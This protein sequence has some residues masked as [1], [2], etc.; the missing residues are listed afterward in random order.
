MPTVTPEFAGRLLFQTFF[1]G[2]FYAVNADGSELRR[3]TDGIDPIW[4]PDG[5]QIAFTRWRE[6]RGLWVVDANNPAS[7]RRV[8]D[9]NQVR[10]S[11]WSPDAAELLFSRMTGAG[12]QEE[13]A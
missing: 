12:R 6:P 10:W 5:T 13:Q 2:D 11:S 3:I 1:G 9:W 4:S 7:E 8:F